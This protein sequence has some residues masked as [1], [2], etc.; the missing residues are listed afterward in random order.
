MS[1]IPHTRAEFR[2]FLRVNVRSISNLFIR[3]EDCGYLLGYE[4]KSGAKGH[5]CK[6]RRSDRD[7]GPRVFKTIDA[8][9]AEA[10][11]LGG[12]DFLITIDIRT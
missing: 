9:V 5:L 2:Q 8:C 12:S 1:A 3:E 7:S 4:L 11:S 10:K 6:Q